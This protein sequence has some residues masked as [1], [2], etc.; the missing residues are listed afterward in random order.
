MSEGVLVVSYGARAASM[1]D[2]F[3]RSEHEVDLFIV[4][5]QK[6]PFNVKRAEEHIVDPS[7][8]VDNIVEFVEKHEDRID[9]GI[10]GPEDPIIAGVRDEVE[11]KT[12]ISMIC[13]TADFAIEGSKVRQRRLMEDV[14]PEMNPKFKVFDPAEFSSKSEVK[15]AVYDYLD[16]IGNE[17]AVK[18]DTPAAGKGVGVW[19]DH[20]TSRE[21]LFEE[22]F[23]PNFQDGKVIIERKVEGEEFSLQFISDG[24]HLIETPAVRDY[25]RAFEG[26]EGPNTGGMGSYKAEG[27]VLPF[28][29]EGDWEKA[30]ETGEKLHRALKREGNKE[31]LRGF[32]LYMAYVCGSDGIKMFEINSRPGD[33]EIMNILPILKDDFVEVCHKILEG[34]LSSL[35]FQDRATVVTYKVPWDYGRD[36]DYEDDKRLDLSR[37]KEMEKEYSEFLRIYPAALEMEHGDYYAQSSRTIGL[38]GIGGTIEKARSISQKAVEKIEGAD[39][40]YR[41]DIASKEHIQK[42]KDHMAE[43]RR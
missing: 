19:G 11:E 23:Y 4:D 2:L 42:S 34:N 17:I 20:F 22:F 24:E 37:A 3:E 5:K 14:A 25:K 8:S 18:P 1:V 21:E 9:F 16:K 35:E 26:E 29:D 6:N 36:E 33:P 7:L 43:L 32:P 38:V 41:N 13:P 10:V 40:R 30:L 12:S 39:L 31:G 15:E 28:M 27:N